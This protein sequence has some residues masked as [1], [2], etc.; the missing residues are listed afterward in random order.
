M[1]TVLAEFVIE[2]AEK[3]WLKDHADKFNI[4]HVTSGPLELA[5]FK[6]ITFF[7]TAKTSVDEKSS[8]SSDEFIT[9]WFKE[10]DRMLD[11]EIRPYSRSG[12]K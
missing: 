3:R 1:G 8:R 4:V 5:D 12:I 6:K 2:N 9:Y 10:S 7:R 11:V